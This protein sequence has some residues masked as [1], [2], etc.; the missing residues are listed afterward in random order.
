MKTSIWISMAAACVLALPVHAAESM[1]PGMMHG[2]GMG[3]GMQ[4]KMQADN[5]ISLGLKGPQKQHQLA[6]MRAHLEAVSDIVDALSRGEFDQAS[7][8]ASRKLGM[9]PQMKMMCNSFKQDDFRTLA[10]SFHESG[11]ELAKVLKTHDMS[12]SLQALRTTMQFC[13]TCHSTYRQ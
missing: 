3:M 7:D 5:R 4:G 8:T 10:F 1:G 6:N 2:M 11:D 12:A 9:T 13:T